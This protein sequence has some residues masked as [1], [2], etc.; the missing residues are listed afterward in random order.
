MKALGAEDHPSCNGD[1]VTSSDSSHASVA[2][3]ALAGSALAERRARLSDRVLFFRKFLSKGLQVS[4]AV[5][6]SRAM[7]CAILRQIDL[8][9]P[10]TIIELGAG[11]GPVTEQIIAR[12]RPSHRFVAVENDPEFCEVLRRRFPETSLLEVDASRIAEPLANMGVHTVDYVLS[13]LPTPNLPLRSSVRLWR[14]LLRSLSPHGLFVQLTIAPLV[15]RRFYDRLF[16]SVEY[17]MIW[18]NIPPG[19][20]YCCSKPRR[21]LVK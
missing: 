21:H 2:E 7:A 13:G 20:V 14:W 4:S 19:G 11:T 16:N 17:R 8:S 12:L 1:D 5:P 15:Y 3:P 6:S 9:Q 18:R 10:A